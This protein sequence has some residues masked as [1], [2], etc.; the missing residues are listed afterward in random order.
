MPYKKVVNN[1]KQDDKEMLFC[2]SF[3]LTKQELAEYL[4]PS[5]NSG[6]FGRHDIDQRTPSAKRLIFDLLERYT[7]SKVL[8][9]GDELEEDDSKEMDDD[10][11]AL[12]VVT[13]CF[14]KPQDRQTK[15]YVL[16]KPENGICSLYS[17]SEPED[18]AKHFVAEIVILLS[19][20]RHNGFNGLK[21]TTDVLKV[22]HDDNIAHGKAL[23]NQLSNDMVP[24]SP[25]QLWQLHGDT[26]DTESARRLYDSWCIFITHHYAEAVD[27]TTRWLQHI[28]EMLETVVGKKENP[29]D[30][31]KEEGQGD[32][33]KS[34]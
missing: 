1:A 27:L 28:I 4:K 26:A 20:A 13:P 9:S 14:D 15:M 3:N 7:G 11:N 8:E 23:R 19:V 29:R 5:Q 25:V 18:E 34:G 30:D 6:R 2:Q 17:A 32:K 31:G 16:L 12:L 33:A 24:E 21:A 10:V 22:L